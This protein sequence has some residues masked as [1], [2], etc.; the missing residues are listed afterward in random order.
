MQGALPRLARSEHIGPLVCEA[1]NHVCMA[2]PGS[3]KQRL[4]T[5]A[6]P[7]VVW[8]CE[9]CELP[10]FVQLAVICCDMQSRHRRFLTCIKSFEHDS[11][12]SIQGAVCQRGGSQKPLWHSG[13]RRAD[14]TFYQLTRGSETKNI[15]RKLKLAH[16]K[17]WSRSGGA[18]M[19]S[20]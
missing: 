11:G 20:S 5:E 15:P 7:N 19:A 6:V 13:G 1:A 3:V 14:V 2:V 10:H 4:A 12:S 17:A 8:V 9:M 16:N 18:E